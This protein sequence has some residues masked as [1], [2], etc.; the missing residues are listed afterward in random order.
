MVAWLVPKD[1]QPEYR[2]GSLAGAIHT[3]S[4]TNTARRSM[5]CA[6]LGLSVA[7][8]ATPPTVERPLPPPTARLAAIHQE[9]VAQGARPSVASLVEMDRELR[10]L[11]PYWQWQ[12]PAASTVGFRPEWAHIGVR[13]LPFDSDLLA[14]T[15]KLLVEAH[16]QDPQSHR[17]YTL[18]STVF[19]DREID[20]AV[21]SPQAAEAYL[22]EF[23]DG[24]F[25]V[26]AHLALAGFYSDLVRI[27]EHLHDG[28]TPDYKYECYRQYVDAR[29]LALQRAEA[30]AQA[31]DHASTLTRLEPKV[32]WFR[33]L[34]RDVSAGS[35]NSW[36]YCAD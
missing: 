36:H 6:V 17:G 16:R 14:Y 29:P 5:S 25:A 33:E 28:A 8:F 23:P 22:A 31:I 34:L 4:S 7:A 27:L 30:R 19:G 12:G 35:R 11:L 3:M 2:S 21:P 26:H 20:G 10:R 13:P 9:Y 18:Y 15:G 24:P 32:S 1:L